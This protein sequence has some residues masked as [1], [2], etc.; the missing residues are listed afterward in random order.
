VTSF[1]RH[2]VFKLQLGCFVLGLWPKK[3]YL[4][5]VFCFLFWNVLGP[6]I[7]LL[8]FSVSMCK[9]CTLHILNLG[10]VAVANGSVLKLG[11]S[12]QALHVELF[13]CILLG[14]A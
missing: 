6:L 1:L 5:Q 10:L 9:H 7:D 13:Y 11:F 2:I 4:P 12:K 14:P 3:V 8:F